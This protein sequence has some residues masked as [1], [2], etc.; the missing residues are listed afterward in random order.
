MK[1]TGIVRQ[2]DELGRVV[3][4]VEL[5]RNFEIS[6]NNSLEIYVEDDKII[7]KKYDP[8]C[9]F[10][11]TADNIQ[12]YKN[13]NICQSCLNELS[14]KGNKKEQNTKNLEFIS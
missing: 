9:V 11:N 2:V 4:P 8:S 7:L 13:K 10:C 3:I 5:R 6:D 1:S 12:T 14:K